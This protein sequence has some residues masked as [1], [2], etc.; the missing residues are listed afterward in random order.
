MFENFVAVAV[1]A[2]VLWIGLFIIYLVS[3]QRQHKIEQDL[4]D[5]EAMLSDD[6]QHDA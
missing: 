5:L 3:S 6:E 2:I 4:R 1:V